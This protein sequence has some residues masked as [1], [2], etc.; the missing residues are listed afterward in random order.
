[1]HTK[2]EQSQ[3]FIDRAY[4]TDTVIVKTFFL[5]GGGGG[6]GEV[7]GFGGEVGGF[8]GGKL[9]GFPPACS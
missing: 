1:M 8:G 4:Y 7:G 9:E 2:K 5:G 6:G 3:N